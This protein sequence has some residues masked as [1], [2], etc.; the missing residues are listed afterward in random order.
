[1]SS[2]DFDRISEVYYQFA[3][4]DDQN[5]E[6]IDKQKYWSIKFKAWTRPVFGKCIFLY[7]AI[8]D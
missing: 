8:F 7:D 3:D 2:M 4:A 1:M 6:H 5:L